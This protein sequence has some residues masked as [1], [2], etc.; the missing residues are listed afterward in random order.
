MVA[1]DLEVHRIVTGRDLERAGAELALDALVRDHRHDA[2]DVRDHDLLADRV[3]VALVVG[4]DGDGDVGEHRRGADGRDRDVARPVGERI[5][6]IGERVVHVDVLDLEVRDR[7]LVERAPVDD[8]LGA[9]DPAPVPEM[10]EEAH[11]RLDVEVVHCEALAAVVERGA[12]AAELAHDRAGPS[13]RDDARPARRTPRG[14]APCA[15]FPPPRAAS[16]RR[17]GSRCRRGRIRAARACRS[18]ASGASG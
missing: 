18:R 5:A 7:R 2:L 4:M 15:T 17:S 1:A 10:D 14:R 3:A 12:E 8:P 13:P 11:D 6:G 9:V 16:R